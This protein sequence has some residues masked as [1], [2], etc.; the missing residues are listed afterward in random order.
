VLLFR[1]G[2]FF[3]LFETDADVLFPFLPPI[4]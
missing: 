2:K 3:E 4:L 1:K